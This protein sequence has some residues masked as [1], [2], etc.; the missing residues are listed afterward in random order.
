MKNAPVV[1]VIIPVHNQEKY[2]GRCIRS[3]LSQKYP[4]S[5]F[6]IIIVD[7]ASTDRTRYALELFESDIRVLRNEVQK[8]LP[9]SLNVGI[10]AAKGRFVVRIDADDYV[11][12]EYLNILTLHLLM[13]PHMDAA[14]CDYYL[15]DDA[16]QHLRQVHCLKEPI[17]CGIMFRIEHLIELGL[18]DDGMKVHEDKDLMIRFIEKYEVHRVALP[19]YRYRKH[20]DNMTNDSDS[21]DTYLEM[22]EAKHGKERVE[23]YLKANA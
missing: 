19:L 17:G 11:H 2:I 20:G 22:L 13:N 21:L 9:G 14:A 3:A 8:G 23:A 6:E 10:K 4:E 5:N 15:V 12:S 1:S 7:D 18:Y 16:E